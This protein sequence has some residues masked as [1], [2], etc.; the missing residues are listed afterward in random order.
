MLDVVIEDLTADT[1]LAY[2]REVKVHQHLTV[3]VQKDSI[4]HLTLNLTEH[5]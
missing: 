1:H 5:L 4:F 3:E 2:V